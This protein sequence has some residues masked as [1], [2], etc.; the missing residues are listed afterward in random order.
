MKIVTSDSS[1]AVCLFS[2]YIYNYFYFINNL[3]N[4]IFLNIRFAL[5]IFLFL[6]E[7]ELKIFLKK[8]LHKCYQLLLFLELEKDLV[9]D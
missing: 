7:V 1:S 2:L 6:V 9:Y 3:F 5:L 8:V 4:N